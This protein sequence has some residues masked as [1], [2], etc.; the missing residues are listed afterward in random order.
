MDLI[1]SIILILVTIAGL[2][3][4]LV[5]PSLATVLLLV[6]F[7]LEQVYSA[8]FDIF[9]R[10]SRLLNFAFAGLVFA[11]I[12]RRVFTGH[13]V[14]KGVLNP[15]SVLV[16]VFSALMM[17]SAIWAPDP[18][19]S[20]EQLG[21]SLPYYILFLILMPLT[22]SDL[23][24]FR[25]I[26]TPFMIVGSIIITIFVL[27]PAS[28]FYGGRLMMRIWT[29][30]G[31]ELL[32]PLATASLGS[33]IVVAAGL[34]ISRKSSVPFLVVRA[35]SVITGLGMAFLSGS[36]GQLI[37]AVLIVAVA[38]PF[39]ASV[40]SIKDVLGA[41]FGIL[42]LG[43]FL[44]VT[45]WLAVTLAGSNSEFVDA[46]RWG[47]ENLRDAFGGR[48]AYFD[49]MLSEFAANPTAWFAGLGAAAYIPL[50]NDTYP[51]NAIIQILTEQGLI[52]IS[53]Y[54]ALL[55]AILV[56]FKATL[57][58]V[59][60][61]PERRSAFIC[62]AALVALEFLLSMKQGD[63][64]SIPSFFYWALILGKIVAVEQS[65]AAAGLGA[66]THHESFASGYE[67]GQAEATAKLQQEATQGND[68]SDFGCTM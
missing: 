46:D 30:N 32:N 49:T 47:G 1:F 67:D 57:P 18:S 35:L 66:A 64:T 39:R 65:N 42:G 45:I 28:V 25:V 37:A 2:I 56:A 16:Y 23:D 20:F 14:L 53:L 38:F 12:M 3:G 54:F 9:A 34:L 59:G 4:I 41:S 44:L 5:R 27:S 55:I 61:S 60:D 63:V 33:A 43:V 6:F 36:R 22:I 17:V 10:N 51:H 11:A 26:L 15:I 50:N 40:K 58:L 21:F 8:Q 13:D 48:L 62:L 7:P 31:Y 52:G 19:A 29:G 24:D 68:Q